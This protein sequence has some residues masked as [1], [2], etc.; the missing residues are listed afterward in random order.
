MEDTESEVQRDRRQ[1]PRSGVH[2]TETPIERR[3]RSDSLVQ[4]YLNDC[5][6]RLGRGNPPLAVIGGTYLSYSPLPHVV[7][8]PRCFIEE[9]GDRELQVALAHE[10]GHGSRR[11][12]S[13][14]TLFSRSDLRRLRE[15]FLAD[16]LAFRLTG[17]TV[18]EFESSMRAAAALEGASCPYNGEELD[19]MV[20]IRCGALR[21]HIERLERRGF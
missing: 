11:W 19:A 1:A 7:R 17:A 18:V 15:E 9:M 5:F 16:L 3:H 21:R 2:S 12:R 14:F 10:V 8:V 4:A 20:E 6:K 13:L